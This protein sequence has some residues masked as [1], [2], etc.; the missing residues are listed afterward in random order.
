MCSIEQ[1]FE[2]VDKYRAAVGISE[3]TL[4]LRLFNDGKRI[5]L[6]RENEASD[7]GIK[8]IAAAVKQLSD[9]WPGDV[10]WPRHIKRPTKVE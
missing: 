4:S 1:F 6:I 7:I 5:K 8:K 9:T 3:A 2:L 10:S